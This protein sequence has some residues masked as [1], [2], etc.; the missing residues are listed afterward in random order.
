MNR[1]TY[2]HESPSVLD[3]RDPYSAFYQGPH[4]GKHWYL[5]H[6]DDIGTAKP[7]NEVEWFKAFQ[8]LL[9]RVVNSGYGRQLMGIDADLPLIQKI[10]K[11]SLQGYLGEGQQFAEFRVGAKWANVI[12][13]RWPEFKRYARF[14]YDMPNF[15]T[16]LNLNGVLVPAHA[17]ATY[18]PDPDTETTTVD[19]KT[20]REGPNDVSWSVMRA[21]STAQ[22]TIGADDDN[23]LDTFGYLYFRNTQ[24][25]STNYYRMSRSYELFDTSDVVSPSY[26]AATI[27]REYT[28]SG[29]SDSHSSSIFIDWTVCAPASNTAIVVGDHAIA[30]WTNTSL[31]RSTT[32]VASESYGSYNSLDF[33]AAGLTYLNSVG[34]GIVKLGSRW[35]FDTDNSDSANQ[36]GGAGINYYAAD[37]TGTSQDPKLFV[38][39][40][41]WGSE[42][43]TLNGIA[44]A[45]I[46]SLNGIT[47]ANGETINGVEF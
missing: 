5:W 47:P 19:G 1:G 25:D 38:T 13:Y 42:I 33:N 20:G 12:R 41:G 21:G 3:V 9:L 28:D 8:P 39:G 4:H 17:T 27:S 22:G 29:S 30:N 15:F 35:S 11:S 24:W 26:S 46:E 37:Q 18:Y 7:M 36:Q 43:Q 14:F 23:T 2:S 10:T 40:T 6:P 31:A 32:D 44:T 45:D 34:G 16:L